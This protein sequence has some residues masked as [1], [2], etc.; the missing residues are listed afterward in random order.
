MKCNEEP[1]P[2]G[3]K[4]SGNLDFTELNR[5]EN[6][7]PSGVCHSKILKIPLLFLMFFFSILLNNLC[8]IY[9]Q[10]GDNPMGAW[11][12]YYSRR[13]YPYDTIPSGA[14]ENAVNQRST[15]FQSSGYQVTGTNWKEIG[16]LPYVGPQPNA[17]IFSGRIAH[18]VYDPRDPNE[19]GNY[20]YVTGAYGGLWKTEDGGLNWLNK[21]GVY[22]NDLPSLLAGAFTLDADRNIL[23][24]GTTGT[25]NTWVGAGNGMRIFMSTDD[26]DNWASISNGID[27][28]ASIYKIVVSPKDRNGNTLFAATSLGLFKTTNRGGLWAKI[29]PDD[30][31]SLVCTDVCFSPSGETVYAVGPS[32]GR[33]Y[34]W[35]L[36][37]DGIGYWRSDDGGNS[38]DPVPQSSSGFPHNAGIINGRTLCAVSNASGAEDLVWI[39]DFHDS[40]VNN[41]NFRPVEVYKST[42]S[43]QTFSCRGVGL[44]WT[45]EFQLVIS[46]SDVDKNIC[47]AGAM[48]LYRTTNGGNNS[49]DWGEC[50]EGYCGTHGDVLALDF[51]P[52]DPQK[53]TVGNDGGV[54][55]SDNSGIQGSWYT[56]NQNLGSL[57]L[58][59]GL[60]SSTYDAN[61][62]AG[63]L[64]DFTTFSYNS[65][66]GPETTEWNA[67]TGGS[68]DCGNMLASPFKSKHFIS[69]I[70]TENQKIYYSSNGT[71]FGEA[72]G[73]EQALSQSIEVHPFTN[74]PS[75]P[76]V[77]YT[78][79]FA[80][81]ENMN[82]HFRKSTN[83][84]ATWGGDGNPYRSF[85]RP[86]SWNTQSIAPTLIA[87][88][89]SNPNTMIMN[90]GNGNEFFQSQSDARS[91][92]IKSADGGLTW[93][94]ID[95][96]PP[97][98][99][100]GSNGTPDRYFSDIEF[101]PVD[102]NIL[103]LTVSGYFYP[104]TN[105]GHVFKSTDGGYN[106]SP[107]SGNLP[108]IP[109]NDLIIH[110]TGTGSSNKELIIAT[111][112]GIY[113]YDA[114]EDNW[115]EL[116]LGFPNTPAFHL[117]YNRLS[118]KLRANTWGRGAWEIQLDGTT[119]APAPL[120]VQDQLFITDNVVN[121]NR[122]IIV[123]PGGK[124][125]L[126]HSALSSFSMSF[127]ADKKIIVQSGG[128]IEAN[129]GNTVTLTSQSGTW[130]GIEF[131]GTGAGTLKNCTFNN[132]STPIVIESDG[133]QSTEHPELTIDNCT[134]TNAPVQITNR[135]EVTIQNCSFA[136]TSGDAPTVLGVLS[137]GSDN[138]DI[139][140]NTVTSSSSITSAGI[141]IVYGNNV[142]V[143]DNTI[144]NMGLGIS[145]SNSDAFVENNTITA[146]GDP[147][148]NI[149]IGADNSYSCIINKNTVTDYFYGI[150]LYSSS[151]TM[152]ENT[153]ETGI[154]DAH[155]LYFEEAS[156]PRLRPDFGGEE[157][158]WDAGQNVARSTAYDA[159]Y[160]YQESI[161]DMD[162]G[163]N[164]IA[165][166]RLYFNAD[167]SWAT[168]I[169]PTYY[170]IRGNSWEEPFS[171]SK[172]HIS[173]EFI[174]SPTGCDQ[175]RGGGGYSELPMLKED[176]G[177][178]EP[179][180]PLIVN[181]G[182]GIY[183][184]LNTSSN[185]QTLPA[186]QSLFMQGM[187]QELLGNF[188]NAIEIYKNV[189]SEYRDSL[190]AI[191]SMKRLVKCNDRMG[192]DSTAYS[193]LRSYFLNLASNNQ[194]DTAFAYIARELSTKCLVR[195]S[196]YAD[197]ITEYENSISGYTDSLH[198][199]NAELNI[200][201][202]YMI[203]NT[204]HGDAMGFT[205]KLANLK[206]SSTMDGY[207]KL[208]EKLY[209]LK[210]VHT[211]NTV[212]EKF[213]LSQNYPNP[214][215]P[216]TKI[217]FTLPND[218]KVSIKI[219]DIL[220]RTV[221]VLIDEFREKGTH[222]VTFDGTGLA[223]GVY[224]YSIEA[225][226][227]KD[228][229]KMVLI[230]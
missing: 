8:F 97:I 6:P 4:R 41:F 10:E 198:I 195:Q 92:I 102:E 127:A 204:Q 208:K 81:W 172:F 49:V 50:V 169:P 124:L 78:V 160:A 98:V 150:K 120:Y 28:G 197:A 211:S 133:G 230:K 84:G 48:Y 34:P 65:N 220:G 129:S 152:L 119:S 130:G 221:R 11:K 144:E 22:P 89:P 140:N 5:N 214:F 137:T 115:R 90:F 199:L 143:R 111:D 161:P 13:A 151:P 147:G 112:A 118:G 72:G 222:I 215:N 225:G 180:Q 203:M 58:L 196:K 122:D 19:L 193:Q 145:L 128:T 184:T 88:S 189:I 31:T 1:E 83:Y 40:V 51:N 166:D 45:I 109:V 95:Y 9:S 96:D 229:K 59:W 164:T 33:T 132:T 69:N 210:D 163:C 213:S 44:S 217:N 57:S 167:F 139:Y 149:G 148:D 146:T 43:G 29:I 182:N 190:S 142:S 228:T 27:L 54:S 165:A 32:S 79:R 75:Q 46:P 94:G 68:G 223:S 21:S 61:F 110:Y 191:S 136:Y 154:T 174:Y 181:H 123:G 157:I 17:V 158:I 219:Y 64:H 113:V 170:Y 103:Y 71:S 207:K 52:F 179:P 176:P 53:L 101:D 18:V 205:G 85:D 188:S 156:S 202:T 186:D 20:I 12:W 185:S 224:F 114:V 93:E 104:S 87:I 15:L 121:M 138:V 74:H 116:A 131:Q 159:L 77:V 26:G 55:R 63:G 47:F 56:C 226:H 38:F 171:T 194:N 141:S 175:E 99:I 209:R 212:P 76:G 62:V 2:T 82:V 135:P 30:G 206:P 177:S 117:D 100:G 60:A 107:I 80:G 183:D 187:K 155:C 67:A 192:S 178:T 173:A 36:I 16:P 216:V 23:Y 14:F 24:F 3:L 37:F 66:A 7:G 91:R 86:A 106:W 134:F 201:E 42:N 39:I 153:V 125:T 227:F 35:N 25:F 105:E 218:S 126:G 70:L 200:I 168:T 108:D 73:Y 162:Y